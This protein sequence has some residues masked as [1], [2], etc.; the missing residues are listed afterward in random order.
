MLRNWLTGISN[1]KRSLIF[2]GAAPLMWAIWC[3]RNDLIFGENNLPYLCR[4][5]FLGSV[6]AAILIPATA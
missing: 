5:L 3:T 2:V 1:K 6:L 4:L